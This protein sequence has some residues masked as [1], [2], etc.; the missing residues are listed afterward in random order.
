MPIETVDAFVHTILAVLSFQASQSSA[1]SS[2]RKWIPW[3]PTP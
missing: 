2:D 3:C 1:R